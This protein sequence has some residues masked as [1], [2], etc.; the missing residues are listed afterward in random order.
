MFSEKYELTGAASGRGPIA[1]AFP[2]LPARSFLGDGQDPEEAELTEGK[3][4]MRNETPATT[5]KIPTDQPNK[6]CMV[7]T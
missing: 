6:K 7:P 1:I 5:N 3:E 4:A 2:F